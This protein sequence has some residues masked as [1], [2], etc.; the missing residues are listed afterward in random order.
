MLFPLRGSTN[1]CIHSFLSRLQRQYVSQFFM[2]F[3]QLLDLEPSCQARPCKLCKPILPIPATCLWSFLFPLLVSSQFLSL[4]VYSFNFLSGRVRVL[5][6]PSCWTEM[7]TLWLSITVSHLRTKFL[8]WTQKVAII[9]LNFW[10][11]KCVLRNINFSVSKQC[12][13]STEGD[14]GIWSLIML[15][16][17]VDWCYPV[18]LSVLSHD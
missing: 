5:L 6:W 2:Y 10:P 15:P 11:W 17:F 16:T 14:R 13:K 1:L 18:E 9:L 4:V 3:P 7:F 8:T 12:S